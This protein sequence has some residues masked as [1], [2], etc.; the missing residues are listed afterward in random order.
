VENKIVIKDKF[1]YL[2][3]MSGVIVLF[4]FA[5]MFF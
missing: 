4:V 2:V 3:G 1:G 5:R